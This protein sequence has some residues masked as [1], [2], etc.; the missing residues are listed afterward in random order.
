M[1]RVLFARMNADPAYLE[2]FNQWYDGEHMQQASLIPGYGQEHRRY[3]AQSFDGTDWPYRPHPEYTAV[4]QFRE[5]A[6]LPTA[7]NSDQYRAWSGD[8][9][10]RWRDRTSN[11]VSVLSEQIAGGEGPVQYD[12]VLIV[13]I[14]PHD[15]RGFPEW[16]TRQA[17]PQASDVP[18]FGRHHR[19]FR[20]LELEGKYWHYQPNPAYTAL[21][22]VDLSVDLHTF[23]ESDKLADWRQSVSQQGE[24]TS[25]YEL[26]TIGRRIY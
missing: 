25:D 7:I 14:N 19:L 4:Y 21:F 16:C 23:V 1:N 9:L 13:Q 24:A 2:D 6:D 15:A 22:E 5:D 11:E 18:G 12:L 17:I 26:M 3:R 10:A 8:F 20:S